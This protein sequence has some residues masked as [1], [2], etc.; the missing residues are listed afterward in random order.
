MRVGQ[1]IEVLPFNDSVHRDIYYS[2]N[3]EDY[4]Y[5]NR[6]N[7]KKFCGQHGI[8]TEKRRHDGWNGHIYVYKLSL[9]GFTDTVLSNWVFVEPWIK[10]RTENHFEKDLFEL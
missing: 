10:A 1:R 8:I 2:E 3:K 5:F 9:N 6:S 4:I 7:M